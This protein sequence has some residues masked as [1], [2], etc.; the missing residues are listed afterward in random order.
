MKLRKNGLK[1]IYYMSFKNNKTLIK[2]KENKVN[3]KP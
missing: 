3:V 2:K 1:F